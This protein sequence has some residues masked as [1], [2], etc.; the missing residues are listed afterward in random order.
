[1][2]SFVSFNGSK[3]F[4]PI[5]GS[6][7]YKHVYRELIKSNGFVELLKS[8][9]LKFNVIL[10]Y[11]LD[12]SDIATKLKLYESKVIQANAILSQIPD[13]DFKVAEISREVVDDGFLFLEFSITSK[14]GNFS[15]LDLASKNLIWE[16][17]L[18]VG[19]SRPK[20]FEGAATSLFHALITEADM[21]SIS[22]DSY[23]F[24]T[25]DVLIDDVP[26]SVK[27]FPEYLTYLQEIKSIIGGEIVQSQ[28]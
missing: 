28:V 15:S 18:R 23:R 26:F 25:S 8:D 10:G 5:N 2:L 3:A 7:G 20:E 17:L 13:H 14:A 9:G 6:D 19:S 16:A 1:M 12:S 11:V 22:K 24:L 21:D 4:G 27:K